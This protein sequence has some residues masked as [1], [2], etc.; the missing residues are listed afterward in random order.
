[1]SIIQIY[2]TFN[3]HIYRMYMGVLIGQTFCLLES[4]RGVIIS[5]ILIFL[6]SICSPYSP[7]LHLFHPRHYCMTDVFT[8]LS[9]NRSPSYHYTIWHWFLWTKHSQVMKS[10]YI[11]LSL[12]WSKIPKTQPRLSCS[13]WPVGTLNYNL[14]RS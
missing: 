3:I 11:Q 10:F 4:L 7:V 1:L 6:S 2:F 13:T 9:P 14:W 12:Q 5:C 8:L